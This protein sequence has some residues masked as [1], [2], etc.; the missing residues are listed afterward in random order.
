MNE[1][2]WNVDLSYKEFT[3][4][5]EMRYIGAMWVN[6][7][8]DFNEL[9]GRVPQDADWADVQR[10]PAV[11]YH[12]IRIDWNIRTGEGRPDLNFFVG[13][14]N[15]FDRMPPLGSTGTGVGSAIYNIRGRNLYGGFRAR[16]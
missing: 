5:Y 16:F 4:G 11:F 14:D 12:D 7:Y 3:L 9:Q 6:A 2:R 1:F 13:V 8:E 15:V 10:F